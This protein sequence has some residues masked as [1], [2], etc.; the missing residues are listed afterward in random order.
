ML[1][2]VEMDLADRSVIGEW[3]AWYAEHVRKL[4]TVPGFLAAQRFEAT[5][6]TASPFVAIYSVVDAGVLSSAPYRARFG[7]DSAAAWRDRMTNWK[8]NLLDGIGEMPE[9]SAGGWLAIHDRLA[10]EAPP[11]HPSFT[12]LKSLGLDQSIVERGLLAGGH[13]Q[14]APQPHERAESALRVCKP[15]TGKSRAAAA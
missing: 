11:L 10:P 5:H 8:R 4:L 14:A 6:R 2:M 15:L 1:Y 9:V 7:P 12:S 13:G 3:Q